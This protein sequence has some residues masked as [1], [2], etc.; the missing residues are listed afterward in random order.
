MPQSKS[1]FWLLA[2]VALY[3]VAHFTWYLGTPLG[4]SPVLDGQENLMLARQIAAG[5][6]PDEPFYRAMLYPALLAVLPFGHGILGLLCH[7]ANTWLS[8]RLS[9]RI[10]QSETGALLSGALVGLNPVLLHFA[11]DPL[12]ITLAITLFLG[13]LLSLHHGL[14]LPQRDG[15]A[16]GYTALSGLLLALATLARPHFM[17]V[18]LPV[19]SLALGAAALQ[20]LEWKR[21]LAFALAALIPLLAFGGF[22][23]LRSGQFQI[24]PWQ[25]AYNLWVSNNAKANGLYFTQTLSFHYLDEHRNPARLESE[26]LYRQETGSEGSI[27]D[28]SAYWRSKTLDRIVSEPIDWIK[29][30]LFKLYAIVNNFEQYNNKTFAFHKDL[31]PWLRYNPIS[32]GVLLVLAVFSVTTLWRQK[33][34]EAWAA[35]LVFLFFSA[36]LL[37][38]MASARFRLP[39]APF[40][41]VLAGGAPFAWGA[42]RNS[43][44]ALK[45]RTLLA[46]GLAAL[47]AFSPFGPINSRATYIQ[48]AM[49]LA[50]AAA[51]VGQDDTAV[52]WANYALDIDP[53]R[54]DARRLKVISQYN[55]AAT[56]ELPIDEDF[57]KSLA[58]E[59]ESV[60]MNDARLDFIRGIAFW[61]IGRKADAVALW[62][63][64]FQSSGIEA[65]SCLA[66]LLL[67]DP[68]SDPIPMSQSLHQALATGQHPLLACAIGMKMDEEKRL[69]YLASIGMSPER[70]QAI[71]QS[72]SRVIP[73]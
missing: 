24:L 49:L 31:S 72:L 59:A 13:C 26:T 5:T 64:Q 3:S 19:A 70:F 69:G 41:A 8:L 54:N 29:L 46:S 50:D 42:F 40:L 25:G 65:S 56:G 10:W 4:Q 73:R 32:W 18:L 35:I 37:L 58:L 38:Y 22:Q 53:Q 71:A 34:S 12:D 36:G 16:V 57:W 48:D 17:A 44:I 28:Q 21:C 43:S 45:R 30:E 52:R 67:A 27:A 7:L 61:N 68:E 20:R 9:Y 15:A 14:K 66:A 60:P 33:R 39:L 2:I 55:L 63:E 51:R 1:S 62:N 6:L 47:A 23:K 11:F